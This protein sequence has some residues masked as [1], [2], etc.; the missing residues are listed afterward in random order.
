MG[1]QAN[2]LSQLPAIPRVCLGTGLGTPKLQEHQASA[3]QGKR[4]GQESLLEELRCSLE[5]KLPEGK[6][7]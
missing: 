1:Q 3:A 6:R 4:R 5:E 7:K 2:S